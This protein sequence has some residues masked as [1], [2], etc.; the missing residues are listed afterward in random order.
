MPGADPGEGFQATNS[1]L[2]GADAARAPP[3]ATNPGFVTK[4]AYTLGWETT[5]AGWA[6]LPGTQASDIMGM[7]TPSSYPCSP[8]SRADSRCATTARILCAPRR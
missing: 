3:V 1:Q 6:P 4:F 7:Y 5:E 2:F 8:A